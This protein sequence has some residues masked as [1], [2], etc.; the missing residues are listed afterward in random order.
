MRYDAVFM[1]HADSCMQ[2]FLFKIIGGCY[3]VMQTV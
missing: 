1:R 2:C 3:D